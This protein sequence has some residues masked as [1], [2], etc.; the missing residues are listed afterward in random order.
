M[1]WFTR[2][3][4][5][6]AIRNAEASGKVADSMDVR[7]SIVKRIEAGEISLEEGQRELAALKRNAS[8]NGQTTRNRVFRSS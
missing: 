5:F 1:D 4:K 3:Q 6:D 2:N 8:R 7:I